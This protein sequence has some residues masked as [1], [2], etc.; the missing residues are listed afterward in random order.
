MSYALIGK[1][2]KA[3]VVMPDGVRAFTATQ[4]D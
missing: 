1:M 4:P 2:L 3:S